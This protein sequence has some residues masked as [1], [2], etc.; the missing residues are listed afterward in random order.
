MQLSFNS[1]GKQH[2]YISANQLRNSAIKIDQPSF[3][4]SQT[5]QGLVVSMFGLYDKFPQTLQAIINTDEQLN[6]LNISIHNLTAKASDGTQWSLNQ[7]QPI[8]LSDMKI[9]SGP[10]LFSSTKDQKLFFNGE[11]DI[12]NDSWWVENE[13]KNVNFAINSQGIID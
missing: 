7:P 5:T 4:V 12:L 10:L 8:T 6:N 1:Q 2:L 9:T 3:K 13:A 11:Y